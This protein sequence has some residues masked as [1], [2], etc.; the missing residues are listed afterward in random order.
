MRKCIL[1]TGS[2]RGIG[3]GIAKAFAAQGHCN[4]V[5]NG[6]QDDVRLCEA[7]CEIKKEYPGVN[8]MGICADLSNYS[9]AQGLFQQIESA[10]GAVDVLV[11]NAGTAH[12][13]LFTDMLPADINRVLSDNLYTAIHTSHLAIPSM[14]K[15]KR[16]C[17]INITSVWGIT[18][19]SCEVLYSTTKAAVIGLTKSLAKELAPSGIRVNAIACGAFETRM[20][21]RLEA[22]EKAAFI[23]NIPMGRFGLP[24]EVGAL[25]VYLASEETA[26]YLTGQVIALD[27]GLI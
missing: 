11:N 14:V 10:F 22:Q 23:E 25:A 20:N 1:I 3:F 8:V 9:A 6:R 12:F 13:G 21:E 7:V 16:G 19:A 26:S 15:A 17:I 27:G 18:G 2:S 24:S 4:I 5:L